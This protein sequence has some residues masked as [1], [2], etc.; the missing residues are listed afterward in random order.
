MASRIAEI[1]QLNKFYHE[2]KISSFIIFINRFMHQ[3]KDLPH[4][5]KNGEK[6]YV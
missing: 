2:N 5:L 6:Y 4:L 1:L 3:I